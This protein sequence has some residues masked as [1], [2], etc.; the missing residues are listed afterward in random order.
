MSRNRYNK[1]LILKILKALLLISVCEKKY[2]YAINSNKLTKALDMSINLLCG[3]D[4]KRKNSPT[5]SMTKSK[6]R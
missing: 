2:R 3:I 5:F 6:S 4:L 1:K